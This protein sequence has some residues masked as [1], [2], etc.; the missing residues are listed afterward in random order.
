MV[1]GGITGTDVILGLEPFEMML[2]ALT[3]ILSYHHAR[4][5]GIEGL[6]KLVV[7]S[8]GSCF[9]WPRNAPSQ[10]RS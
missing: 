5:T 10:Q 8:S 2:L 3:L 6:M 1:L 9:R 7:S 4:L